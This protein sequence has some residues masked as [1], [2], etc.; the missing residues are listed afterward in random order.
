MRSRDERAFGRCVLRPATRQLLIAGQPAALGSRAFDLLLALVERRDRV[1]GKNEL[2]DLVWPGLV[3]EE[4]NLQVHVSAL[5]KLLGPQAITT[6]PGRGYQFSLVETDPPTPAWAAVVSA[7]EPGATAAAAAAASVALPPLFGRAADLRALRALLATHRLVCV[8]GAGGVGKTA[9]VRTLAQALQGEYRDGVCT[10]DLAPLTDAAHLLPALAG[11]LH[12]SLGAG[13]GLAALAASLQAR[14]LL[15]VLDNCEHLQ[16]PVAELAAALLAQAPQLRLLATSQE[17]LR[18]SCEQVYRLATLA[19]PAAGAAS[20]LEQARDAGALQLFEERARAADQHFALN[21][22]NV[23]AA[24]DICRQLDGIALAIE[25]AAARVPLLGVEGLRLRLGERLRLLT[26]GARDLP[27]RHRTLR[28]ALEWSHDLLTPPQQVVYRRL[29]VMAGSFGLEAAQQVAAA[30][31]IDEWDVLDA[32]GALVDKSMV[33]A[34]I[35]PA[36]EPRFRLLETVRQH[37][38]E[39]L[40][41]AG[42]DAALRE[43]HLVF[44]LALALAARAPLEGPQQGQWLDRLELDRDNLLAAHSACDSLPQGAE[45]GLRL[46]N[47]LMR[48]WLSRSLLV[49][50]QRVTLEAL[51]R[52]G[53]EKFA[54]LQAEALLHAG[55]LAAYRGLDL[56]AAELLS[57]SVALGRACGAAAPVAE[58][59]ARLGYARMSLDDRAGARACMEEA[60]ALAGQQGDN[61]A[62]RRLVLGHLAELERLEGRAD[63]AAPLYEEGLQLARAD[64]DRLSVMIALNN[65]AMVAVARGQAPQARA[66]LVESLAI[67]DELDSRRGRLVVMEVCAGLAAHLGQ[68]ER[69]ARFD[70]AAEVH[71]LQMG[72]RRDVV[73]AAF[74]APHLAQ[75]RQRLGEPA[76]AAALAEGAALAYEPAIGELRGWLQA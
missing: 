70:G 66:Q 76:Y 17:P 52:P 21:A 67:C 24:V 69:A 53:A 39:Q 19:L 11:A 68:C 14:Q 65:L 44:F 15:L 40:A 18:L 27:P 13:P 30:A 45:K 29:G 75:A 7:V 23:A 74:L 43:R 63:A 60:V 55:R 59:L 1:V 51:A 32:L 3:V 36:G 35:G 50:G 64:G 28:A 56:E 4:N 62:L 26:G 5:R 6:V 54:G 31:E 72:R 2:L 8:V 61:R 48:Y 9:L 41:G 12:L 10:I 58:A 71:T 73:D 16:R 46:V 22:T 25:L 49:Q 37:A 42:E 20:T 33:T 57:R 34:E 47:A 38:L